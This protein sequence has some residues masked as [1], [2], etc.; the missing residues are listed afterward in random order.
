MCSPLTKAQQALTRRTLGSFNA[1]AETLYPPRAKKVT[2]IFARVTSFPIT[3]RK[4]VFHLISG[5]FRPS[6]LLCHPSIPARPT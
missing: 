1:L 4:S 3:L 2:I 5:S 6:I